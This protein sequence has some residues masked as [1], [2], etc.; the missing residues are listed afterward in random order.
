M[1]NIAQVVFCMFLAMLMFGDA[2]CQKLGITTPEFVKGMQDSKIMYSISGFFI[3]AQISS[4]LRST[5][6]FEVS[7]ND[8]QVYSKL[9]TG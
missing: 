3:F 8:D 5:G 7:I 6:A 2:I 9:E 4:H 1:A